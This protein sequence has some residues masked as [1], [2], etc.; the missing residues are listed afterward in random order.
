MNQIEQAKLSALLHH[1][2]M[3]DFGY[4]ARLIK[5]LSWRLKHNPTATLSPQE[6]YQL[7]LCCYHYRNQLGGLVSFPVPDTQP[8]LS[9]YVTVQP[10]YRIQE[11]LL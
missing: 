10:K 1:V 6:K 3:P 9:D 11:R 5:N 7:D 2:R 8:L 4:G